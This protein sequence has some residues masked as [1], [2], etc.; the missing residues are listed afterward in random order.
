M[1]EEQKVG[2]FRRNWRSATGLVKERYRN[3]FVQPPKSTSTTVVVQA[4]SQKSDEVPSKKAFWE[5]F[6]LYAL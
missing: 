4:P 2:F 5:T 6:F 3:R 1:A